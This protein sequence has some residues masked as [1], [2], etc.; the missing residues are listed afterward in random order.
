[1]GAGFGVD[2]G[3]GKAQTLHGTPLNEVL[4]DDLV[5]VAGVNIAVPDGLG[6][7]DN[8]GTV[9]A[10]IQAAGLVGTDLVLEACVFDCI[11]KRGFQLLGALRKAAGSGGRLVPLVGANKDMM[12]KKRHFG[13]IRT[14]P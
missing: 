9:L 10:L 7:D 3:F 8:N 5:D 13:W 4:L 6:V 12:L 14:A 1:M 11:L 2:A